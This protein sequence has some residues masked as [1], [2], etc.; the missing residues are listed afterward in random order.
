MTSA[1]K[2]R[3]RGSCSSQRIHL[4]PLH[5]S[6][7]RPP[8]P[9]TIP[10]ELTISSP[11]PTDEVIQCCRGEDR[12]SSAQA[13]EAASNRNTSEE[14]HASRPASLRTT[15]CVVHSA[16]SSMV[17]MVDAPGT[18]EPGQSSD[19]LCSFP[20]SIAIGRRT[21]VRE[22]L[23]SSVGSSSGGRVAPPRRRWLARA[24]R[25]DRRA[26]RSARPRTAVALPVATSRSAWSA[27]F[28]AVNCSTVCSSSA[29]R[30][31]CAA[32]V[33]RAGAAPSR[34]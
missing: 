26:D 2:I 30:F 28:S 7:R 15:R 13:F 23:G 24:A 29:I 3:V 10:I 11:M 34:A 33:R 17:S 8:R 27:A 5:R 32:I 18:E 16:I 14:S 31:S 9:Q 19:A 22:T 4:D 21:A 12:R 25:A 6:V 20:L 1:M